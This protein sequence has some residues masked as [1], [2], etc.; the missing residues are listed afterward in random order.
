MMGHEH[1]ANINLL[2]GAEVTGVYD[3]VP[4]L[5]QKASEKAGGAKVHQSIKEIA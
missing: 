2:N 4:E 5:A 1:V 3:P